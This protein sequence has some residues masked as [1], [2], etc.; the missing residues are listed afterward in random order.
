MLEI[1]KYPKSILRKKCEELKEINEETFKLAE[2]MKTKMITSEG[3]GLAG[4]QVGV[5]KRIIVVQTEKGPQVFFNPK[6]LKIS[7]EAEVSDEGCLSLPGIYL[8]IRR[9][10]EVLIEAQDIDKKIVQITAKD[11]AARIF[12]HEIDHINGKVII[13]RISFWERLKIRKLLKKVK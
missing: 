5:E 9:G 8:K 12:Q 10:K 4:N 3:I 7:K 13:D 11:L 2:G 1:Q 6:I